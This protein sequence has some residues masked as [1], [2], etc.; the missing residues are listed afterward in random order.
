MSTQLPGIAGFGSVF[1]EPVGVPNVWK[2]PGSSRGRGA[3]NGF[4]DYHRLSALD[5]RGLARPAQAEAQHDRDRDDEHN[6]GG[7]RNRGTRPRCR[8]EDAIHPRVEDHSQPDGTSSIIVI[9]S[10]SWAAAAAA[11]A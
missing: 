2:R 1:D 7:E 6:L 3:L 4:P 9:A 8:V 5:Q 11:S 10:S